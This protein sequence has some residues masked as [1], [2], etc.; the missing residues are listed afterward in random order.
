M[1]DEKSTQSLTMPRKE[2]AGFNAVVDIYAQ[3]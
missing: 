2:H 1:D 3:E